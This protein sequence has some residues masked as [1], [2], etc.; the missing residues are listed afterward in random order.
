MVQTGPPVIDSGGGGGGGSDDG[1]DSGSGGSSDPTDGWT[2]EPAP[3]DPALQGVGVT[4]YS[5]GEDDSVT[6]RSTVENIGDEDANSVTVAFAVGGNQIGSETR[7]V[8]GRGEATFSASASWADL[9][10]FGLAGE[11]PTVTATLKG[12]S[13]W[14]QQTATDSLSVEYV[15]N[16]GGGTGSG[17]NGD[18]YIPDDEVGTSE[19]EN[20]DNPLDG[21]NSE[22]DNVPI[23]ELQG[24]GTTTYRVTPEGEVTIRSRVENV[25]NVPAENV[26]V[27]FSVG[28]QEIGR[29]TKT[30]EARSDAV[31]FEASAT[32]DDLSAYGLVGTEGEIRAE[33]QSGSEWDRQTATTGALTVAADSDDSDGES[34]ASWAIVPAVGNLSSKQT[35]T[36]TAAL[37]VVLG[38]AK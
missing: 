17:G 6:V 30:L 33:L 11:S 18:P 12:G 8:P 34:G 5:V 1:D 14:S 4:T 2:Y 23:P 26:T 31:A 35:T 27:A 9:A 20:P 16:P 10:A 21:V 28:G 3:P 38:V 32:W 19:P 7:T 25:G 22:P 37:V 13:N 24:V 15:E 29:E 36:L